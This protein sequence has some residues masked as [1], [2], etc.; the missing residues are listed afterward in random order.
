[1]QS[2]RQSG[3]T[4]WKHSQSYRKATLWDKEFEVPCFVMLAPINRAVKS[5]Q[6]DSL[7]PYTLIELNCCSHVTH[8]VCTDSWFLPPWTANSLL[9]RASFECCST[10]L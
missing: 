9:Y 10:L 2:V 1:M 8:L 3:E 6:W 7:R 5:E 4:A